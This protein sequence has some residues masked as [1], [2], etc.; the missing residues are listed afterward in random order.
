LRLLTNSQ[1]KIAGLNGFGLEV[2]ERV[3]LVSMQGEA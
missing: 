1:T 2:V 3:P